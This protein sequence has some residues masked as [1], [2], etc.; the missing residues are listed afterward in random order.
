MV[1][2]SNRLTTNNAKNTDVIYQVV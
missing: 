1:D 2:R